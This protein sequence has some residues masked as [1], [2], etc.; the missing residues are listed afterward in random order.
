MNETLCSI[1]RPEDPTP[2]DVS[3]PMGLILVRDSTESRYVLIRSG[4]EQDLIAAWLALTDMISKNPTTDQAFSAWAG[5]IVTQFEEHIRSNL[6][7]R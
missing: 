2:I 6:P 3:G 4:T 7:N 1:Q 5:Q